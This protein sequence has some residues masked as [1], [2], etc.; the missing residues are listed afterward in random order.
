M[1]FSVVGAT[2]IV[3]A[4]FLFYMGTLTSAV[5]N[6]QQAVQDAGHLA[7]RRLHSERQGT[8]R[9][10][11]MS[12]AVGPQILRMNATNTGGVTFDAGGIDILLNGVVS[13]S[14]IT[15]RTVN[16]DTSMV[17]A[18]ASRLEVFVS[19]PASPTAIVIVAPSGAAAFWRL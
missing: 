9:F 8:L 1:G 5:F 7:E 17:W 19:T 3:L 4:G 12:Y 13:T 6:A 14:L 18:P 2:G 16:D 10:D 15:A 11:N